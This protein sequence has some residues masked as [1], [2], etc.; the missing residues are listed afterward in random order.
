MKLEHRE[1][2]KTDLNKLV[3]EVADLCRSKVIENKCRL[4]LNLPSETIFVIADYIQIQQVLLNLILNATQAMKYADQRNIIS[5]V[6]DRIS[7]Y[8]YI[9]V[10][11]NGPG[12]E[13]A[14]MEKLF[15]TFV[16]SKKEGSGIGLAIT[17]SIIE[18]HDGKIWAANLPEG[19]AKFSFKLKIING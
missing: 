15:K 9:S 19:G 16:T 13:S 1:K 5:I 17:R 14:V 11:D 8:V 6:V 12:I 7:E 10:A 18:D 3:S 4:E 2:G